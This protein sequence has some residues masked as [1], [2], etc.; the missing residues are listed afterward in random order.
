MVRTGDFSPRRPLTQSLLGS[1]GLVISNS[2]FLIAISRARLA[3]WQ[4]TCF[5]R[6]GSLVRYQHRACWSPGA[7][8]LQPVAFYL[9]ACPNIKLLSLGNAATRRSS[10]RNIRAI[11]SGN[12]TAD[13][14]CKP[15]LLPRIW[16]TQSL[17][18]RKRRLWHRSRVVTC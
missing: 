10:I 3:Q 2:L 1:T 5:T 8:A 9:K 11:T 14:K 12:L 15:R 7:L 16:A 6:K 18:I 4:S 17:S 13:T